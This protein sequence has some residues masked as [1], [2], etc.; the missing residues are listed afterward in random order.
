MKAVNAVYNLELN[1]ITTGLVLSVLWLGGAFAYFILFLSEY[2]IRV[3][4]KTGNKRY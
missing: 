2:M 3:L 4:A 1:K